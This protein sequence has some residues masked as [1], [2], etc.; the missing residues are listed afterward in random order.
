MSKE[1]WLENFHI[2]AQS[3]FRFFLLFSLEL[4]S[5]ENNRPVDLIFF[6]C[7]HWIFF[8]FFLT[9]FFFL[10]WFLVIL[11]WSGCLWNCHIC[12]THGYK[13]LFWEFTGWASK[14]SVWVLC[15]KQ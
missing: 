9:S 13:G 4:N 14:G 10:S 15:S 12:A 11:C 2:C 3:F 8:Q 7:D 6:R 5:N 1:A